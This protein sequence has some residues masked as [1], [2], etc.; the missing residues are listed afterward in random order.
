M[1]KHS[2]TVGVCLAAIAPALV[3]ASASPS[4]SL[5]CAAAVTA[6]GAA[7]VTAV[8]LVKSAENALLSQ[9]TAIITASAV[10]LGSELIIC[11]AFPSSFERA[12]SFALTGSALFFAS[13]FALYSAE[14]SARCAFACIGASALLVILLGAVRLMF[15][16]IPLSKDVSMG[17]IF[18]AII[19]AV[20]GI[21]IPH[22]E[23]ELWER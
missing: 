6:A 12:P 10:S 8:R 19:A 16:L 18:A 13:C 11:S 1:N 4:L 9:F 20:I 15:T 5:A 14:K 23:A 7:A 3:S 2:K 17:F 22:K 21:F